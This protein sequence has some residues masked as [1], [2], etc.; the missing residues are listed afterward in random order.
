MQAIVKV[1]VPAIGS[2][3]EGGFFAGQININGEQFGL[4]VSPKADGDHDDIEWNASSSMVEGAKSFNDGAANTEAM[5]AAGSELAKWARGLEIGGFN[6]WY[7]PSQDELEVIYRNLKPT[8]ET[9]SLYARSGI[10]VSTGTYPYTREVPPQ[11][12]AENFRS[13]G[14]HALNDEWYW[15][16]TQSALHSGWAWAQSSSTMAFRTSC[17]RTATVAPAR[18][19]GSSFNNSSIY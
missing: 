16:S 1:E 12:P 5:A 13:G 8:S 3:F 11:T 6:D 2:S 10:N 17:A 7:V 19:A 4:I 14:D 15:S 18:S 9:N